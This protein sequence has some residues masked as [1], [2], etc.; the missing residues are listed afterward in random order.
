MFCN[1]HACNARLPLRSTC[2]TSANDTMSGRGNQPVTPY[3]T[4]VFVR[5]LVDQYD[6]FRICVKLGVFNIDQKPNKAILRLYIIYLIISYFVLK[7]FLNLVSKP[8]FLTIL[9]LYSSNSLQSMIW[10]SNR[11]H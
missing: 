6:N 1:G 8:F 5:Y 7:Y 3:H 2:K 11:Q 4:I 10:F 9:R